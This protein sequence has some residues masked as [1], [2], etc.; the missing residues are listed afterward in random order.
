MCDVERMR[1]V[2]LVFETQDEGGCHVYT[3]DLPGLHTL[4]E[5]REHATGSARGALAFY[6]ERL[7]ED[8]R[9]AEEIGGARRCLPLPAWACRLNRKPARHASAG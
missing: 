2:E 1:E 8:A 6:V 3:P 4:G 7:H 5:G 9:S